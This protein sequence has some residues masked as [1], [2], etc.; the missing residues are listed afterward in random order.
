LSDG[1]A[2]RV[3]PLAWHDVEAL[4]LG[5][6][7]GAP[8]DGVV[9]RVHDDSRDARAGDLFVALNTGTEF[10]DDRA[11]ATVELEV[12]RGLDGTPLR[13]RNRNLGFDSVNR[14]GVG[15]EVVMMRPSWKEFLEC[16]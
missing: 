11:G 10:V 16:C 7:R 6:L 8:A 3:I 4:S 9:R 14:T 5:E 13:T 2:A 15:Q 1:S 12:D